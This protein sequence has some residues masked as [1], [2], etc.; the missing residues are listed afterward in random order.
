VPRFAR[1]IRGMSPAAANYLGTLARNY[2]RR[3]APPGY[4][5]A[6]NCTDGGRWDLNPFQKNLG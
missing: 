1:N 6:M 3:T 5:N 4:W 2:T